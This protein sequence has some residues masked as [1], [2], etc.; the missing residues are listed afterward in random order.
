[1][2]FTCEWTQH[3]DLSLNE[4]YQELYYYDKKD[5]SKVIRRKDLI[6]KRILS[7]SLNRDREL[8]FEVD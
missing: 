1:M 4:P 7:V 5:D 3:G 2:K 6:G 8:V